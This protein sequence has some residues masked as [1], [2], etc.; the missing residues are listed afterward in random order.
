MVINNCIS[1]KWIMTLLNFN[2]DNSTIV[3]QEGPCPL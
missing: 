1:L 2:L 3:V